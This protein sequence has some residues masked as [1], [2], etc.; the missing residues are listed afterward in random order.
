MIATNA[1]AFMLA[2]PSNDIV[3]AVVSFNSADGDQLFWMGNGFNLIKTNGVWEVPDSVRTNAQEYLAYYQPIW[4]KNAIGAKLN[5]R[6][7]NNNVLQTIYLDVYQKN[8]AYPVVAT[9]GYATVA[10]VVGVG[11]GSSVPHVGKIMN[12]TQYL[13]QHGE[14]IVTYGQWDE[15]GNQTNYYEVA[16]MLNEGKGGVAMTP[17]YVKAVI[18]PSWDSLIKVLAPPQV[19]LTNV[20]SYNH[21]GT[22]PLVEIVVTN[23]MVVYFHA[24]T[25]EGEVANGLNIKLLETGKDWPAVPYINPPGADGQGIRLPIGVYHINFTWP[26]LAPAQQYPWWYWGDGKGI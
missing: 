4:E 3:S 25:T 19:R 2:R 8:A 1:F 12:L 7:T 6:D 5:L 24:S 16:F 20:P 21:I 18:N 17:A 11:S 22:S 13:G 23:E 10:P 9:V 26:L 15:Y 14:M